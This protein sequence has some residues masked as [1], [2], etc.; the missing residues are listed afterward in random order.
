MRFNQINCFIIQVV[1]NVSDIFSNRYLNICFFPPRFKER[2][3]SGNYFSVNK[4]FH[5][6]L[7]GNSSKLN[8]RSLKN[9]NICTFVLNLFL[10]LEFIK[11][12]TNSSVTELQH[13]IPRQRRSSEGIITFR[14]TIA[15][16]LFCGLKKRKNVKL[17]G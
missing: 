5:T 2:M 4:I 6:A 1:S 14:V 12:K 15:F 8:S 10:A 11:P 13:D 17:H 9:V 7:P 3:K 16:S